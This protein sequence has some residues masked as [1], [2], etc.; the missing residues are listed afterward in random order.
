VRDSGGLDVQALRI[1]PNAL[2]MDESPVSSWW[3]S[4][5]GMEGY[6]ASGEE[7]RGGVV[8]PACVI[9]RRLDECIFWMACVLGLLANMGPW[10]HSQWREDLDGSALMHVLV[11]FRQLLPT[12]YQVHRTGHPV[13]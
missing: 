12:R 8:V 7:R 5:H 13:W 1:S 3:S 6:A 4:E 2:G 10:S 11:R 9:G